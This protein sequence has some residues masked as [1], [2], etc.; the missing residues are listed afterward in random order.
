MQ[1][2]LA[3]KLML[4]GM[5]LLLFGQPALAQTGTISG[6]VRA[7][8]SQNPLIAAIVQVTTADGGRVGASLTNQAGRFQIVN[9]PAGSYTVLVAITGYE[10]VRREGVQVA[11]GQT[12]ALNFDLASRAI[13][14]DPV[15]VSASRRQERALDAPARVEVVGAQEIDARP[16][17][18][19]TEHLR[20][21]AGVD[22]VTQGLQST[23]VVARGFNNVFSGALLALTDHRIAAIPSLRVN[24]LYM[25]P[26]TN[27]DLERMEVV[28]GPGSALYGPNTANGVLHMFT[29]SPLTYQGTTFTATGG[30]R[31]VF[32]GTG[33]TSHL[34]NDNVGVKLSGEFFRG[35]EWN[36]TDPVEQG[37]RQR[38]LATNPNTLVGL[39]DFDTQRWAV[40][41]RVDWRITPEATAIL[42]AGRSTTVNGVELTGIGASQIRNWSY[43]YVQGRF[44][45]GGL[46]A[47]AYLNTSNAGDTYQL[48]DGAPIIDE[49]R[50][51]V[52]Q[53]QHAVTAAP[54][55]N[56]TYGV[57]Y[58]RT[59]PETGGT[60][61]GIFEDEDTYSETGAFL[62]SE[63]NLG[64]RFDVILAG[65][66]D[67]HS[68]VDATV[69]SPRAALVFKPVETQTFR[70]TYNRAY[71]N[72]GSVQ[73]FLDLGA[74]PAPGALGQLGYT[75]RARGTGREGLRF[76]GPEGQVEIRSP[77]GGAPGQNMPLN[78]PT[79]W[80]M[81]L[82]ALGGLM[83]A[84]GQGALAQALV[85]NLLPQV[86][87]Q[88]GIDGINP[89]T[90]ARSPFTAPADVPGIRESNVST[91]EVGYKGILGGR[92]LLAADVWYSQ[93]DN[94][95]SPLIPQTPLA[96]L[97]P[98]ELIPYLVPRIVPILAG[99]GVPAEQRV[100][101]ATQLATNMASIPGGVVSPFGHE[102]GAADLI[103][104]Y[105]NFGEI[106]LWG[107]DLAATAL[108]G[109]FSASI[110][111]SLVSDD[112][113]RTEGQIITLNA[114]ARKG[115]AS[116]GYR[117]ERL[118][119]NA[120]T[121]VRYNGSFPVNSG[122]FVGI[123][124]I[125]PDAVS[126][127]CVESFTLADLTLGYALP[128]IPGASL[129]LM[130]QNVFDTGYRSFVG[131][132]EIG[133][134]ALLR[135]R[136]TFGQ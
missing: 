19:P 54:W 63:T 36:Y 106:N 98:E 117:N 65:K 23:N 52:S 55:Q 125:E 2:K 99:A 126:E 120:E 46:F 77:F 113:F 33:R 102:G 59:M 56:F 9:V 69:F 135:L 41:G 35:E 128:Q 31:S 5:M 4:A 50:F 67:R 107:T 43:D 88:M 116:V 110:S 111:T 71:S 21:V 133:R 121:R 75:A 27:E 95:I 81:Q 1:L 6:L 53:I 48:R 32:Q 20:G 64:G 132:P 134:M 25:V 101:L 14:L 87:Q 92:V 47:Q 79:L 94:F 82:R 15:V 130:V 8:D 131:V 17:T 44:N 93:R 122:V 136:Y 100:P 123:T 40:D 68:V 11:A 104:S 89:V 80:Q 86:P 34:I 3:S 73:L 114:P 78:V 90:Q 115:S 12:V 85:Q 84:Q 70:A 83:H 62:Q 29:R 60:I 103:V 119:F 37:A 10:T 38:A 39:R 112:H 28:L 96:L 13:D 7:A 66:F 127:P 72:P 97:R 76:A 42:S 124:C 61:H 74:G 57:D 105:R 109:Q 58:L 129:Q 49:S 26:A 22:I 51:F 16:A 118:G 24:A 18:Q 91:F 45:R 108:L 30:D